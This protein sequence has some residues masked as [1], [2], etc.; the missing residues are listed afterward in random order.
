MLI[1]YGKRV[2]IKSKI[3]PENETSSLDLS[4]SELYKQGEGSGD[5]H[6]V[7]LGKFPTGKLNAKTIVLAL[8]RGH[9]KARVKLP[10][11]VLEPFSFILF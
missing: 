8:S 2:K 9:Q 6:L 11:T 7:Q 1:R 5:L 4:V 10:L 3:K